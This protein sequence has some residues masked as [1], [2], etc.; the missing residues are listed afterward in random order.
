MLSP[1]YHLSDRVPG[2]SGV[3]MASVGAP[4]TVVELGLPGS[5][6]EVRAYATRIEHAWVEFWDVD[7]RPWSKADWVTSSGTVVGDVIGGGTPEEQ[8]K[9]KAEIALFAKM[10]AD[11]R[12]FEAYQDKIESFDLLGPTPSQAWE[13]LQVFEDDLKQ[14]RAALEKMKGSPLASRPPGALELPGGVKQGTATVFENVFALVKWL[15]IGAGVYYGGKFLVTKI[16][17]PNADHE[18]ERDREREPARLPEIREKQ[19]AASPPPE[20]LVGAVGGEGRAS[21]AG[22][23]SVGSDGAEDFGV[24]EG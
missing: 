3:R 19:L 7:V 11:R 13:R 2:T 5:R 24:E 23:A 1:L 22:R 18:R 20:A 8:A 12:A 6:D 17:E 16:S 15:V 14:D 21:A 9:A 10:V 4:P